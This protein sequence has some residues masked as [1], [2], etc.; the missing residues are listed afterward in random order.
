MGRVAWWVIALLSEME[1]SQFKTQCLTGPRDPILLQG[2]QWPLGQTCKNAVINIGWVG[3]PLDNGPK[4]A[5]GQPNSSL[6]KIWTY[7]SI[8]HGH[9]LFQFFG[10]NW[11]LPPPFASPPWVRKFYPPFWWF[12]SFKLAFQWL[13]G[14]LLVPHYI[15]PDL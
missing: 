10:K 9:F 12:P 13:L 3:C 15:P 2:S 8:L 11:I 6:K 5:V 14:S 4:L 1:G 7:H